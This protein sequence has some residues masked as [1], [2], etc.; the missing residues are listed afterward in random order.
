MSIFLAFVLQYWKVAAVIGLL[1]LS[2]AVG[3]RLGSA[4]IRADLAAVEARHAEQVADWHRQIA[5][6]A[7]AALERQ[8]ALQSDVDK[9]REGLDNARTRIRDQDASIARLNVDTDRLRGKLGAYAAGPTG[10]DS[11][12]TCQQRAGTLASLLAEGA[13]LLSEGAELL[14]QTAIAHDNRASEVGALLAAWPKPQ[15]VEVH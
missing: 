9:A 14:R 12:A 2:C 8:K 7:G 5:E 10:A 11:L 15:S 4:N 13:G 6:A 1:C 3:W